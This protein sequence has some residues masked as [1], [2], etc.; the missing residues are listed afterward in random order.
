MKRRQIY[1]GTRHNSQFLTAQCRFHEK[2][3]AAHTEKTNNSAQ[4]FQ[5]NRATFSKPCV[6]EK[7]KNHEVSLQV[8]TNAAVKKIRDKNSK[9]AFT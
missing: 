8:I 1:V 2:T 9:A 4:Q 5:R 3:A 6:R 7:I